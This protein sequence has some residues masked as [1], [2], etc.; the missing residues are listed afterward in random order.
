LWGDLLAQLWKFL[1]RE[2]GDREKQKPANKK[3][4]PEISEPWSIE[5]RWGHPWEMSLFRRTPHPG[6]VA[7]IE[8]RDG[9][10]TIVFSRSWLN[11]FFFGFRLAWLFPL[12]TWR[13]RSFRSHCILQR[14]SPRFVTGQSGKTHLIGSDG[15]RLPVSGDREKQK[16]AKKTTAGKFRAA[17]Y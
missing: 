9:V 14:G 11:A 16:P 10:H 4:R 17:V 5:K 1:R 15:L 12:S 2:G 7:K 13:D 8:L 6:S 3:P